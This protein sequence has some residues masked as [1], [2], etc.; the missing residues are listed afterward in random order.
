MDLTHSFLVTFQEVVFILCGAGTDYNRMKAVKEV[1]KENGFSKSLAVNVRVEG[2][3]S[4]E[5]S[6]GRIFLGVSF[7]SERKEGIER[8]K[9]GMYEMNKL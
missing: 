7:Y 5:I 9:V 1:E 8:E 4:M 3:K 6:T 2:S